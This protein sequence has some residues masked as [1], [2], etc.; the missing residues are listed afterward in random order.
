MELFHITTIERAK[1]ILDEGLIAGG[2]GAD[3]NI[4]SEQDYIYLFED[5]AYKSWVTDG[6][7]CYVADAIAKN[8]LFMK[9]HYVMLKIDNK[10]IKA[11]IEHDNVGEV[12]AFAQ[13]KVKQKRINKKYIK[14]AGIFDVPK[15]WV[16]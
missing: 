7:I 15:K 14:F 8:Q 5:K 4:C 1:R 2:V 13:W 6:K 10:G 11:E 16:Q 3:T 12:A 9:G